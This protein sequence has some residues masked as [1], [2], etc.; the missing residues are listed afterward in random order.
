MALHRPWHHVR[1]TT[2]PRRNL[3][4]SGE[5]AFGDDTGGHSVKV[6][7]VAW[8]DLSA[9]SPLVLTVNG[10]AEIVVQDAESY[11]E[12]LIAQAF[13]IRERL[14]RRYHEPSRANGERR[15]TSTGTAGASRADRTEDLPHPRPKGHARQRLG[16]VVPGADEDLEPGGQAQPRS[17][18]RRFYVPPHG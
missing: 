6:V 5:A 9:K 1:E 18:P 7:E 13:G 8:G 16:R 15:P 12:L 17:V 2:V 3:F 4:G 14:S 10:R 11:Q